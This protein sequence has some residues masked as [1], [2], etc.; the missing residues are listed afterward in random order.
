MF[1]TV[2]SGKPFYRLTE[3]PGAATLGE[4]ETRW[5]FFRRETLLPELA[6]PGTEFLQRA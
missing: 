2:C 6:T 1:T 4:R 5:S 3:C